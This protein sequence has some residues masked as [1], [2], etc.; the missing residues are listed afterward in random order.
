M[1]FATV[2]IA[3]LEA[4]P[5]VAVVVGDFFASFRLVIEVGYDFGRMELF[6]RHF[7]FAVEPEDVGIIPVDKFL[8]LR[9]NVIGK[10][11]TFDEIFSA[12]VH[13]DVIRR[14]IPRFVGIVGINVAVTVVRPAA[15]FLFA[16][17]NHRGTV[18]FDRKIKPEFQSESATCVGQRTNQIAAGT[19]FHGVASGV[20]A[21]PEAKAIV[22]FAEGNHVFHSG[23]GGNLHQ[24]FGLVVFRSKH[25]DK[26]VG[27]EIFAVFLAYVFLVFV[28]INHVRH[29]PV[30]IHRSLFLFGCP[31]GNGVQSPVDEHS[32]LGVAKPFWTRM[33]VKRVDVGT[34]R[35]INGYRALRRLLR[36]NRFCR[37][38]ARF[39]ACFGRYIL[40]LSRRIEGYSQNQCQR[41][42]DYFFIHRIL[43]NYEL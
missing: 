42:E 31:A 1:V 26:V 22:M 41:N 36:G 27:L 4:R 38:I 18:F 24:L 2:K 28:V 32:E 3:E 16:V 39:D 37:K 7:P 14:R 23:V 9:N 6:R 40:F 25:R 30:G 17:Y 19:H 13:L 21:G 35:T 11:V 8:C 20:T 29:E 34:V 5:S 10:E 12:H 43:Y 33:P 15:H